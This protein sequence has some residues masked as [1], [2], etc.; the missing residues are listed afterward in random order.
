MTAKSDAE[1]RLLLEEWA[2]AIRNK[3]A[4]RS[5]TYYS[6]GTVQF[7]FFGSRLQ[8]AGESEIDKEDVRRW[9]SGFDGPVGYDIRDLKVTAG[10][11][12]AFCHFLNRLSAK[13]RAGNPLD[14]WLRVTLCFQKIDGR[15]LIS[16]AHES[17]PFYMDGS[18]RAAIDLSP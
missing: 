14:I 15:W 3:D 1:I 13:P 5:M 8:Y 17:V 6:E 18:S 10:D 7:I 16:H 4:D 9:F 12:T 2:E 11:S